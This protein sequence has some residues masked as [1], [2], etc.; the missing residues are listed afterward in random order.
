MSQGRSPE[1]I[2]ITGA[3][4]GVGRATALAFARQGECLGLIARGQGGLEGARHEVE[5]AGGRALALP[6]DTADPEAV[7]AAAEAVE[8]EF[9][10]IDVWINAAMVTVYSPVHQMSPEE[11]RRVTEV[12]YLGYV[13]GTLAALKRM[14]SRDRGVIVQVGSA[15]AYRSIPLQSA[16]CAA[17]S[18]IRGFTDSLRSELIH[19]KSRVQLTMVQL[20]GLN[21]P[22]F[23]WGRSRMPRHVRPV[24][25]VYQPEVAAEASVWAALHRRRELW[26]GLPTVESIL[27]QRIAPGFGDWY[28]ARTAYEGQQ[29]DEPANPSRRDNLWEPLDVQGDFG[30]HGRF[31]G[32][33]RRRSVQLWTTEHP[34][35]LALAALGVAALGR[36]LWLSGVGGR[37]TPRWRVVRS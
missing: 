37:R 35:M 30:S 16:Y 18:A 10:P 4:A 5:Q 21:T 14:R 6:A 32:E 22:Q 17:K 9:G 20:P 2:V 7:E 3:S 8:R 33:A 23:E 31:D 36:G 12:T 13:H 27:V 24:A 28:A 1:V 11:F 29:M 26:V 34:G 19:D 25:P 15:M